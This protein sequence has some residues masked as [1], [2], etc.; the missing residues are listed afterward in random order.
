[1][2]YDN[3]DQI[4]KKYSEILLKMGQTHSGEAPA[5]VQDITESVSE[6][7][8]EAT[9][10]QT[11]NDSTD[12]EKADQEPENDEKQTEEA[13]SEQQQEIVNTQPSVKEATQ[14]PLQGEVTSSASFFARAFTGEG[15]Y[16]VSGA[17]VVV[18]RGDDIYAFLETDSNGETKRVS[19]PAF[20]KENSLVP[21]NDFQSISYSADVFANGFLAQ[22]GLLVSAVGTSEIVLD[23]LLVPEEERLS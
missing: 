15:A 4:I 3:L 17:R 12:E 8:F 21:D 11:A 22:K 1:M 20:E 13:E 6:T 10:Q 19:L 5:D 9:L 23:V 7:D 14:E 16:P 18:Y 2:D